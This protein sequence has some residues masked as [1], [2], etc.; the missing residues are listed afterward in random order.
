MS[1]LRQRAM[2]RSA[3]S[4]LRALRPAAARLWLVS[5]TSSFSEAALNA[6]S[7]QAAAGDGAARLKT[8]V[9]AKTSATAPAMRRE[10]V[11]D[12]RADIRCMHSAGPGLAEGPVWSSPYGTGAAGS[13]G[14]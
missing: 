7:L 12:G 11:S 8:E 3:E 14:R 1:L 10:N 9:I 4:T 13:A 6:F 2:E 5:A